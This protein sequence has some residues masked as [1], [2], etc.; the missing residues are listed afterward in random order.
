M[1]PTCRGRLAIFTLTSCIRWAVCVI[2]HTAR[3]VS[4]AG[5]ATREFVRQE[6]TAPTWLR[7]ASLEQL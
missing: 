5:P 1:L 3:P 2:G 7:M 4:R 6:K